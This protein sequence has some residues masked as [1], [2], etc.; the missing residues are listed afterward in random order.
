MRKPP[1]Y[2][3]CAGLVDTRPRLE[4]SSA[5]ATQHPISTAQYTLNNADG[6]IEMSAS[7]QFHGPWKAFIDK[8]LDSTSRSEA[9]QAILTK[10][11]TF[12]RL[13]EKLKDAH[14]NFPAFEERHPSLTQKVEKFTQPLKVLSAV[15]SGPLS[16]SP[17]PPAS[18][19]FGAVFF[20]IQAANGV[21]EAYDWIDRLFDKLEH[22]AGR[23]NHYCRAN[24]FPCV[25]NKIVQKLG[26]ILEILA[27]FEKIVKSGRYKIIC[28]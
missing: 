25:Q 12:K 14:Q 5:L 8:Y 16:I 23:L 27:R 13:Y 28:G 1:E 19:L 20:L 9:E 11:H 7:D 2:T 4:S 17:F 24:E 22:F 10:V 15:A 26:C 6:P 21:P 18:A 3:S